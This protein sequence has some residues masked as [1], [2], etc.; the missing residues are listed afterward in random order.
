MAT[1]ESSRLGA[2]IKQARETRGMTRLELAGHLGLTRSSVGLWENGAN[3]PTLE[4]LS[5]VADA[6]SV[7]VE[8]FVADTAASAVSAATDSDISQAAAMLASLP[9]LVRAAF[10]KDLDSAVRYASTLPGWLRDLPVPSSDEELR[11]VV[12]QILADIRAV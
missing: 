10:E 4:N 5:R 8:W 11:R 6:L 2:R 7:P 1:T 12:D 9:P 3:Q